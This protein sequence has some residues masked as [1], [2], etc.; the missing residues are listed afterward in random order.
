MRYFYKILSAAILA[1]II[2][3]LFL[4][5]GILLGEG[6]NVLNPYID[7]EF[8]PNYSPE[9]FDLITEDFTYEEVIDLIGKPL[10]TYY[11][12]YLQSECLEYTNDGKALSANHNLVPVQ[13]F[14]WYRSIIC[15]DSNGKISRIEKGWSYD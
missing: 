3:Y 8:A 14:A 4:S 11:N 10:G 7:T 9:K 13:D 5:G 1:P 2:Y 15:F 12:D 6:Y